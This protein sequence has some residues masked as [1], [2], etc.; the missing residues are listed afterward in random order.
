MY[1]KKVFIK[2][3]KLS[4]N[5]SP[6]DKLDFTS[7]PN[8]IRQLKNALFGIEKKHSNYTDSVLLKLNS[9]KVKVKS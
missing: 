8:K 1:R 6:K 9:N 3:K 2:E 5:F 4:I 7:T